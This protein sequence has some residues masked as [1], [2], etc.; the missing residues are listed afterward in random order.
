MSIVVNGQSE[1][2]RKDVDMAAISVKLKGSEVVVEPAGYLGGTF[3]TYLNATRAA[4]LRFHAATKTQRGPKAILPV[5]IVKLK[6][7]GFEVEATGEARD[8][9]VEKL[10][11]RAARDESLK[12]A[13]ASQGEQ[14]YRFQY[15]G[16]RSLQDN[17]FFLLYDDMGLGKTIQVACALPT[18]SPVLV[19]CPAAVKYNWQREL[20]RW[21]PDYTEFAVLHGRKSFR[22]PAPGEVVIT[23]PDILVNEPGQAPQGVIIVADEAHAFKNYKASRT[24]RFQALVKAARAANGKAWALTGTPLMNR[25]TELWTLLGN[26]GLAG[27]A[28]G[29]WNG[30]LRCFNGYPGRWGGYEFGGPDDS[31]PAR[32]EAVSLGR[33]R[34]EV[35]PD[36][37]TKQYRVLEVDLQSKSVIRTLDKAWEAWRQHDQRFARR[38]NED[39]GDLSTSGAAG[40]SEERSG[41][42]PFEEL[43][44]ARA[45]VARDRIPVVLEL[46]AEYEEQDEPLIVFSAHR[47]PVHAVGA[48]DGWEVITGETSSLR[49]DELMQA[50][51]A[52]QLKGLA[53]TIKAAGVGLTLTHACNALFVDLDWTPSWNRQAEDRICRIGQDR[54][55]TITRMVARHP[56]DQRVLELLAAKIALISASTDA[57]RQGNEA[58]ASEILAAVT[59]VG[60]DTPA[61]AQR[62][63]RFHALTFNAPLVDGTYTAVFEDGSYKTLRIRTQDAKAS[64]QPGQRIVDLLTG[65]LNTSDFTGF[66]NLALTGVTLWSKYANRTDLVEA[67]RVVVGD[68]LASAKAYG[69][70]SGRCCVCNRKLTTPDSIEAGIGPVCGKKF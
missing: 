55:V 32:L 68:P 47:E 1:P 58:E 22:W 60:E 41:S 70:H 62:D 51:Q 12:A 49:R 3:Q 34:T 21:R 28:F 16:V 7:A 50:F 61:R 5:V 69:R 39:A 29:G 9:L 8:A 23:N 42:I 46:V 48:R 59:V 31:V 6:E 24:K 65:P 14:L 53:C 25:P 30:F 36:L 10:D 35:L 11:D 33:S 37:P 57:A 4:G 19:I 67:L 27:K 2:Q 26:L 20:R 17:D 15:A 18:S 63:S 43:S 56:L 13:L 45:A 54:G 40:A 38:N 64:F 66:G 52:G 44:A